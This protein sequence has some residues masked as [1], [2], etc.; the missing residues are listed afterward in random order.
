M[1]GRRSHLRFTI[2][3]ASEGVLRILHD[4]VMEAPDSD[5]LIAIS[6]APGVVGEEVAVQI[7]S[8]RGIMQTAARVAESSPF[9]AHGSV[10]YRLRLEHVQ[11]AGAAL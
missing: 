7:L 11:P 10:R 4:V 1:F 3:P 8:R 9:M 2:S 5:E 6:R